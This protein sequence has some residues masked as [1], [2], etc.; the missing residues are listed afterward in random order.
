MFYDE[1]S[2]RRIDDGKDQTD[3]RNE[4]GRRERKTWRKVRL[5]RSGMFLMKM[6]LKYQV[7]TGP[8]VLDTTN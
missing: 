8:Y 4:C 1:R 7:R 6:H 2:E 3:K 5:E